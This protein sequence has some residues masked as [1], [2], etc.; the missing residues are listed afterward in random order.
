MAGGAVEVGAGE[1]LALGNVGVR[2]LREGT[3][4]AAGVRMPRFGRRVEIRKRS[5]GDEW[6]G[7]LCL[8]K[9]RPGRPA[10]ARWEVLLLVDHDVWEEGWGYEPAARHRQECLCHRKVRQPVTEVSIIR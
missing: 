6:V 1:V 2:R 3:V 10:M 8:G 5:N 7:N 9:T 4:V